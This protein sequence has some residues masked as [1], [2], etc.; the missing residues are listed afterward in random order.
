MAKYSV[1][2]VVAMSLEVEAETSEAAAKEARERILG[3]FSHLPRDFTSIGFE[4]EFRFQVR[5]V[6]PGVRSPI[7]YR[8]MDQDLSPRRGSR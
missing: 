6:L 4:P 3:T 1:Y 8:G 5:E 7:L 2:S